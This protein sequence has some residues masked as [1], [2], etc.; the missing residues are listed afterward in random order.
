MDKKGLEKKMKE[1][2]WIDGIIKG[3]VFLLKRFMI[4]R[5]R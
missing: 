3:R 5:L 1:F 2:G 4:D